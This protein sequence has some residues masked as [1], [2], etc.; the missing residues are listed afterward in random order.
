[1]KQIAIFFIALT[2]VCTLRAQDLNRSQQYLSNLEDSLIHAELLMLE[3]D[4]LNHAFQVFSNI[5]K[6]CETSGLDMYEDYGGDFTVS[7]ILRIALYNR[8]LIYNSYGYEYLAFL[9]MSRCRNMSVDGNVY[10]NDIEKYRLC[11][12]KI[13]VCDSH[14]DYCIDS[15]NEIYEIYG[16]DYDKWS[17][18][19]KEYYYYYYSWYYIYYDL[20][21]IYA[22]RAQHY[23]ESA[24]IGIDKLERIEDC[25]LAYYCRFYNP[26]IINGDQIV[27]DAIEY[28][29]KHQYKL[30]LENVICAYLVMDYLFDNEQYEKALDFYDSICSNF[31][32]DLI[33]KE[34]QLMCYMYLGYQGEE[35]TAMAK[36]LSK[37]NK[38]ASPLTT[39]FLLNAGEFRKGLDSIKYD[40]NIKW[41]ASYLEF[42]SSE[43]YYYKA[44]SCYYGKDYTSAI[45]YSNKSDTVANTDVL[46]LRGIC[47]D[48]KADA[49]KRD[50]ER[51][52]FKRKA[53]KDYR[54]VVEIEKK[55]DTIISTPYAYAMMG[56]M[57]KAI[58]T[59]QAMLAR[60]SDSQ[61]LSD[62]YYAMA[63]IYC[64]A[65]KKKAAKTCI[66]KSLEIE[67]DPMTLNM[68]NDAPFLSP[69]KKT[70]IRLVRKYS[71]E[72]NVTMK[73]LKKEVADSTVIDYRSIAGIF[74]VVCEVNGIPVKMIFDTGAWGVL[75]SDALAKQMEKKGT[76]TE[77]DF[78][79]YGESV[80]ADGRVV[81][82]KIVRIRELKLGD[83]V[84]HDV[85]A[86][87]VEGIDE[88]G[89]LLGQTVLSNF[90]LEI[91]PQEYSVKLKK[92]RYTR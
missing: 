15:L 24:N 82:A 80:V 87:I 67:H 7:E 53:E 60:S 5:I 50:K 9:D 10:S 36:C 37:V 30:Y 70:V 1:M 22:D 54:N 76:L 58:E 55:R 19:I 26:T 89:M 33:L 35:V 23:Y 21:E 46:L 2:A 71:A 20:V 90:I 41:T 52:V 38:S 69:I 77:D 81:P 31:Q 40:K 16:E 66:K 73:V 49:E 85:H 42:D 63:E 48:K 75:I 8:S 64:L 28:I 3:Q 13:K 14:V 74:E 56:Q 84:M 68:V 43:F 45:T 27:N 34:Y 12:D 72:N 29:T 79:G 62:N 18:T 4:S 25:Y 86:I 78:L 6:Q 65:G 59:A 57:D 51:D 47:Y 61:E 83:I 39:G 17:D 32:T 44:F 11:C 92:I 91:N 88:D